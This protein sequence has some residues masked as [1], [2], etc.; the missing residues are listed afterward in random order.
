M[1]E[2]KPRTCIPFS[3]WNVEN[4]KKLSRDEFIFSF[5]P[6]G[7]LI[8]SDYT[9][10]IFFKA[11]IPGFFLFFNQKLT[12]PRI[13]ISHYDKSLSF[14]VFDP[15]CKDDKSGERKIREKK[16]WGNLMRWKSD[17]NCRKTFNW[18]IFLIITKP[19]EGGKSYVSCL[20]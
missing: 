20:E 6:H 19:L 16:I 9:M 7:N 12:F 13:L 17:E 2:V 18:F 8:T 14:Y 4:R 15:A 3:S 10:E 5:K 11:I 1:R